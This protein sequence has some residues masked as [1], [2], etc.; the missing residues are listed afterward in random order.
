MRTL[1]RC[2][3]LPL[4][5]LSLSIAINAQTPQ[6][7]FRDWQQ[8]HMTNIDPSRVRHADLKKYLE[9][10]RG[11]GVKIDEVGRSLAGREIYQLQFGR[12]QFKVF[13]WSQM[14]GDEPSATSA[15]ID[16][17]H[18][19]QRNRQTPWI[20]NLER[21]LTIRGVPMLNPDGA[22]LFQRRNL[23]FIDVNRDARA[24]VTPEGRLLKKLC[25]D[26]SPD[27][28]FNLHNQNTR[29]AVS[30]TG[31]QATISL[32][33][34]PHDVYRN[35][36]PGR[37]RSK[38]I[39]ALIIEALSPFIYGHI[40]RYDDTF[41]PRAFGDLISQWGTPVVLIETGALSGK[42]EMDLVQLNFIALAH[43]FRGLA[44]GSVENANP[45]LYDE[46]NYNESGRIFNLIIR[47][48]T[49]INR[50]RD[51]QVTV[52]PFI[53]D[54]GINQDT[55]WSEGQQHTRANIQ[56]IGDLGGFAGLEEVKADAYFVVPA[57]GVLRNGVE[58][59]FLFYK[60]DRANKIDWDAADLE[61]RF[62]PDAVY[63][64]G[65]W[66]GRDKLPRE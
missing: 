14:H 37:V 28:G 21:Q 49:V 43:A 8:Q 6:E 2:T 39:C 59:T 53:A 4:L 7:L 20:A 32:L 25:D 54:I 3:P 47:N 23:Q 36:N 63:R 35:D 56:E 55:N 34:V 44:D 30:G 27:V 19:L 13:L 52:P 60:K 1:Y 66:D 31:K 65:K 57:R 40:A 45:A 50:F 58:A 22:D 24:L 61:T 33:A 12:G 17:F 26:W 10:L 18:Y 15:L 9:R 11:E 48:A 42:S 5:V 41:N 38:K 29:T 51:G 64:N 46:L 16:L 62:P